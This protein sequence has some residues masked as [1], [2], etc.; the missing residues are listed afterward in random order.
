M[1]KLVL[2]V[3]L[4]TL[5]RYFCSEG[6]CCSF[7]T[8]VDISDGVK[9]PDGTILHQGIVYDD[10]SII[11]DGDMVRGCPCLKK[12]CARKCCPEVQKYSLLTITKSSNLIT[13]C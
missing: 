11:R 2:V 10:S 3:L 8:S 6:F 12:L 13:F 4:V 9:N 1:M 7:D 5:P